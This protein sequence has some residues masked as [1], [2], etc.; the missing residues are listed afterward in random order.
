MFIILIYKLYNYFS[1]DG[2]CITHK[3]PF[4]GLQ[5]I[6]DKLIVNNS[7]SKRSKITPQAVCDKYLNNETP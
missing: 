2:I 4:S 3:L 5:E 7:V 6:T 1:H